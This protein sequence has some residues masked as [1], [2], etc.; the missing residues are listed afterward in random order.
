MA[1]SKYFVD[2]S[3]SSLRTKLDLGYLNQSPR[4]KGINNWPGFNV[5]VNVQCRVRKT[6]S[7]VLDQQEGKRRARVLPERT[8]GEIAAGVTS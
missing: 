7:R 2:S 3:D 4:N 1:P 8:N 5:E 6:L